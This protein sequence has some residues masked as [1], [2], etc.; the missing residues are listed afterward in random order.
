MD[1]QLINKEISE[2]KLFRSTRSFN[3]LDGKDVAD[4]LYLNTMVLYM[5]SRIDS[6]KDYAIKS[7]SYTHLRAHETREDR[8]LR[9]VL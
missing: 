6:T 1:L 9:V 8:V 5:L 7:V 4:I 3:T 2:A